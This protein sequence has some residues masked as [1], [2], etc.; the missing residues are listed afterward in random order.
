MCFKGCQG[1]GIYAPSIPHF[2]SLFIIISYS[3]HMYVCN[4]WRVVISNVRLPFIWPDI[5]SGASKNYNCLCLIF[6]AFDKNWQE[7]LENNCHTSKQR[8]L[9]NLSLEWT[10]YAIEADIHQII[11]IAFNSQNYRIILKIDFSIKD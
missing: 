9:C 4:A 8:P 5:L 1:F 7:C 10:I 6:C 11:Q 2:D 3:H